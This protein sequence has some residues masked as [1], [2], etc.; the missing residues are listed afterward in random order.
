MPDEIKL[1]YFQGLPPSLDWL[2]VVESGFFRGEGVGPV[3][4]RGQ[5]HAKNIDGMNLI[6]RMKILEESNEPKGAI[7]ESMQQQKMRK[8]TISF[9]VHLMN[10]LSPTNLN[11][12]V[13]QLFVQVQT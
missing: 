13:T 2:C 3:A 4:S 5:A 11:C 7:A 12:S 6:V 10:V 9:C 1:L 8:V